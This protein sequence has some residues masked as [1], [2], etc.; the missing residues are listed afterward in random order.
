MIG[1]IG[2]MDIE[3]DGLKKVADDISEQVISGITF[4]K[5]KLF[6][7]DTVIAQGGIGKINAALCT[8]AMI[9]K[10]QPDIIINIGIAGSLSAKLA[11]G[12]IV[13]ASD[14]CQHDYDTSAI[15]D[16]VGFI[17]EINAIKIPAD[18]TAISKFSSVVADLG[19]NY[20]IGTIASG[21]QFVAND[22]QKEYIISQF[23]AIA[24]EME[25]AGVGLV[26]A[27]NNTPFAI[28]RAL[29]D[30]AD[31]GSCENY[32]TFRLIAAD[33]SVKVITNFIKEY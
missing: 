23:D 6:G 11:I 17:P 9:L 25:A 31:E 20:Q 14:V 22:V 28:L 10:Y 5:C 7:K 8:E 4:T 29:S 21:D 3:V 2:A 15:G 27:L 12:D 19:I 16:I 30:S 26:C 32:P 24:C 33:R 18:K 13:I 1:I